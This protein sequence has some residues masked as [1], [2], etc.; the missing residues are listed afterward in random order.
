MQ[1]IKDNAEKIG[2]IVN[3]STAALIESGCGQVQKLAS[4]A[5]VKLCERNFAAEA[6]FPRS[7]PG[8]RTKR[9]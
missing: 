4:G 5:G 3:M 1:F 6:D 7:M 8:A 2:A 9:I